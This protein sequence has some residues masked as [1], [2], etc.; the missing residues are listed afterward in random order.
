MSAAAFGVEQFFFSSEWRDVGYF[1][2]VFLSLYKFLASAFRAL[3][4]KVTGSV[5]EIPLFRIIQSLLLVSRQSVT[6]RGLLSVKEFVGKTNKKCIFIHWHIQQIYGVYG[7]VVSMPS[8]FFTTRSQQPGRAGGVTYRC[9]LRYYE[10]PMVYAQNLR[11]NECKTRAN[12]L[13][14]HSSNN[15]LG[16]FQQ[17]YI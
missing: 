2:S 5:N 8:L 10:N 11:L 3:I 12:P 14:Y 17:E 15:S 9:T 4:F 13:G 1:N 6:S 7:V 16:T